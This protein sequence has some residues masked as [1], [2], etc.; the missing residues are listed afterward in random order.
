MLLWGEEKESY[1]NDKSEAVNE[2]ENIATWRV[3]GP[4]GVLL[5]VIN[6]IKTPQQ[7]A[8][9]TKYQKLAIKDLPADATAEQ[10]KI[11]EPVKPC[12]TR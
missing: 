3:D 5:A 2:A 1:D 6:Y 7:Y 8:L 10:R 12:V 4:L 11:K 9:F